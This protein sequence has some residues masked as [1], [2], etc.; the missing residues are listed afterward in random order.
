M[1]EKAARGKKFCFP[2][3]KIKPRRVR[4]RERKSQLQ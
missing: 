1:E 3:L 4:I 2:F